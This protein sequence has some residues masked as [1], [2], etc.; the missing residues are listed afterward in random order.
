[1][2]AELR[3]EKAREECGSIADVTAC[4]GNTR[5][6]ERETSFSV[7]SELESHRG[8]MPGLVGINK[9]NYMV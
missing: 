2:S 5:E 4:A 3:S 7:D 9:S 6:R 8:Q 1:M